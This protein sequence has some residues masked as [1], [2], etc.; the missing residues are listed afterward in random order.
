[1]TRM[2]RFLRTVMYSYA[3]IV[4]SMFYQLASIPLALRFLTKEEFGLWILMTQIAGYLLMVDFGITY[5]IARLL[6]DY[7]D[8]R[9]GGDYGSLLQTGWLV[10]A[11][12]ALIIV[13]IGIG[14]NPQIESALRIAPQFHKDFPILMRW[15]CVFQAL[16]LTTRITPQ[17]L[18]AHQRY[19][20]VNYSAIAQNR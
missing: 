1:M 12:Q 14:L 20:V 2:Q 7:K 11:T 6:I 13:A 15:L 19:D 4:A 9:D 18:Y 5:A 17:V 16:L 8:Q 10:L 3:A